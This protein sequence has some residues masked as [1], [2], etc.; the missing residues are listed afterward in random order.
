MARRPTPRRPAQRRWSTGAALLV[1]AVVGVVASSCSVTPSAAS[2]NGQ[3]ISTARLNADLRTLQQTPAG[4]CLLQLE[5]PTFSLQSIRGTG[6]PGTYSV[7]YAKAV[8]GNQ[9]EMVLA[10]QLADSF[11]IRVTPSQLATARTD[12]ASL[13]TGQISS[14]VQQAQAQG[15]VSY[16]AVGNGTSLTGAELLA[17]LPAPLRYQEIHNQAV[18]EGLLARGADL[19]S[20]A[21]SAYYRKNLA[22]FTAA[23][24]SVIVTSSQATAQQLVGQ[25]NGGTPFASVAK[26]S[27]IDVQTAANGGSI[28]CTFTL[29]AVEQSL[30]QDSITVGSPL[31]PVQ[32]PSTGEWVIYEV[33]AETV[34]PLGQA[35]PAVLRQMLETSANVRRVNAELAVFARHA[36]VFV[37]PRYGTWT[38]SGIVAP[39]PPPTRF[40]SGVLT[41]GSGTPGG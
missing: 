34:V 37:D 4:N 36:D 2:A 30:Q 39:R 14:L 29:A 38:E 40:V 12:L 16:C 35:R 11:G 33:T 5:D 3:D 32:D 1:A 26:A 22:Q 23:C 28:G 8:L 20:R 13:L 10:G 27:S 21:V 15:T 18:N 24:V 19:S 9:L 31:A 25:L 17:G 6:G 7:N 41:G